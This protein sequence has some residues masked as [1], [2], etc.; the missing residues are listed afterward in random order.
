[1]TGNVPGPVGVLGLRWSGQPKGS[2][3]PISTMQIGH[4]PSA[5][6]PGAP[7]GVTG[8]QLPGENPCVKEIPENPPPPQRECN[9]TADASRSDAIGA[10][11]KAERPFAGDLSA[12]RH[13]LATGSPHI[14]V[15]GPVDPPTSRE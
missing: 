6:P 8:T 3:R 12:G 1:M 10:R 7:V 14:S 11:R 15:E 5:T 2:L 13:R 9:T 4:L